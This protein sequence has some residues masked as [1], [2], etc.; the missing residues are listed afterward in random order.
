[1]SQAGDV[2]TPVLRALAAD[3]STEF[4]VPGTRVETL[5]TI[6]GRYSSVRRVRI[7]TPARITHAYIKVM[8]PRGPG[9]E[10]LA[11]VDR[12]LR[13]EY[14]AT[15][16]LHQALRQDAGFGALRPIALM[17]DLHALAT[18]EVPGRPWADLLAERSAATDHQLAIARRVGTWVRIYQ[19]L[20]ETPG[21]V[22]L[23]ER[24]EYLDDRL[25]LIEGRVISP[26]ERRRVL[27]RFDALAR[28][29]G[30]DSVRQ[31]PIHADLAPTNI[32]VDEQG[33]VT[34]LD[35]TMAKAGTEY[36]DLA[37]VYFH[38]ELMRVRHRARREMFRA[39]QRSLLGGYD[40]S[41][42][43]EHPLFRM[44]LM[45]HAICHV[46]LLAERRVPLLD[47][48]YRWF[49]RRRWIVC[50]RMPSA[51]AERQVA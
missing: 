15:A 30:A 51:A 18:E 43:A 36:H 34:V 4:G 39:L 50:D 13:R 37:H 12:M 11:R 31:V 46:A 21:R 7:Q 22:E 26:A 14:A 20:G 44:M 38:L 16:A 23:A 48:A 19:G 2:F 5:R 6:D 42:S 33:R 41:L 1:M 45:Q 27:D 32:V 9:Q 24:R 40:P 3:P 17:P 25:K 10:E 47:V 35:F 8:K 49:V 29:I 28:E